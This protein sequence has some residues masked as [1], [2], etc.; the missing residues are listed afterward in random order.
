MGYDNWKT[1]AADTGSVEDHHASCDCENPLEGGE[2]G[3]CSDCVAEARNF[4][5]D[6]SDA[7]AAAKEAA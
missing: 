5:A 4:A 3:H 2:D 6:C 7:L 1:Q